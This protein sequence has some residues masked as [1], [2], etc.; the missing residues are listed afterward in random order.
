MWEE[1]ETLTFLSSKFLPVL[2]HYVLTLTNS[3][4]LDWNILNK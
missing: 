3:V 4:Q 2:K 1:L